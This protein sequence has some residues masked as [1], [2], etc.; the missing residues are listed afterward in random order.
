M[1]TTSTL[2]C[3]YE[4]FG[5]DKLLFGTDGFT[6]GTI[7]SVNRMNITDDEKELIFYKNA[8]NLLGLSI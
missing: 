7:D 8:I 5:V 1:G 4:F 6:Q 2:M 3:G